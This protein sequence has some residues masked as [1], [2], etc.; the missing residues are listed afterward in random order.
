MT[1]LADAVACGGLELRG[2]DDTAGARIGEMFFGRAV[3]AFAGD[4]F[5]SCGEYWRAIFVQS[6]GDMQRV[7]GM[8]QDALFADRP[9]EIGIGLIFVAGG[10]V[11]G[12]ARFVIRDRRLEQVAANVHQISAGVIAG[13]DDPINVVFTLVAAIFPALPVAGGR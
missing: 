6:F 3:A 2:V 7:A 8:T 1:L 5:L 4:C 11:I 13:A 10:E 9:R 12:L